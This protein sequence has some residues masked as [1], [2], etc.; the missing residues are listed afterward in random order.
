MSQDKYL[1][2]VNDDTELKAAYD[3]IMEQGT[4]AK[5]RM[6]FMKKEV[7]ALDAEKKACWANLERILEGRNLLDKNIEWAIWFNDEG[8]VFCKEH[9]EHEG[10]PSFLRGMLDL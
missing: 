7:E 9:D 5:E 8:Q 4:R 2:N 3:N 6:K 10:L 1:C